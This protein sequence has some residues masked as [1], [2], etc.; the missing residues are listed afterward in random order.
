MAVVARAGAIFSELERAL[1]AFEEAVNNFLQR[2][3]LLESS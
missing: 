2:D 1:R 3:A